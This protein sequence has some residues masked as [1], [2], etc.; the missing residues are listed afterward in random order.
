MKRSWR[1][2]NPRPFSFQTAGLQLMPNQLKHD[3]ID[4]MKKTSDVINIFYNQ[5]ELKKKEH[6][7]DEKPKKMSLFN[8]S[9]SFLSFTIV[10]VLTLE[11]YVL[12]WLRKGLEKRDLPLFLSFFL[13]NVGILFNNETFCQR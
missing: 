4:E 6:F 7:L 10:I 13:L 11:G 1:D 5:D 3:N 2:S 9:F 8:I 12:I